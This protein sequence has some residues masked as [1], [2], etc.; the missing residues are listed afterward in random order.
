[1]ATIHEIEQVLTVNTPFGEAQAL[2]IIDYGI[3]KNTIWVCASFEDGSV[4]HFDSN[5]ISVTINYTLNF[6][7]KDK[8]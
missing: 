2:F 5:Q 3:H 8:K 1:M 7:L 6:N 4:R